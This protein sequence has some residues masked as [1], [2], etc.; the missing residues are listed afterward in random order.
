MCGNIIKT[1]LVKE[2]KKQVDEYYGFP[3]NTEGG[4]GRG[5]P[6]SGCNVKFKNKIVE[7]PWEDFNFDESFSFDIKDFKSGIYL[8]DKK[9]KFIVKGDTE[10]PITYLYSSN[11]EAAYNG[12]G[13]KSLY[14][15]WQL[16]CVD[17]SDHAVIVGFKRPVFFTPQNGQSLECENIDVCERSFLDWLAKQEYNVNYICDLDMDEINNIDKTKLLIIG[18]H[19]EYWTKKAYKNLETIINNGTNILCLS[20]NS[21]TWRVDYAD[22]NTKLVCIKE[23]SKLNLLN[24]N[25]REQKDFSNTILYTNEEF[26]L[27]SS[28]NSPEMI[29][30]NCLGVDYMVGGYGKLKPNELLPYYNIVMDENNPILKNIK[31][32]RIFLDYNEYDGIY[33]NF[34]HSDDSSVIATYDILGDYID[35][36]H[37]NEYYQNTDMSSNIINYSELK[38]I[39]DYKEYKEYINNYI[40]TFTNLYTKDDGKNLH[41]LLNTIKDS[42]IKSIDKIISDLIQYLQTVTKFPIKPAFNLWKI[43]EVDGMKDELKLNEKIYSIFKYKKLI[44]AGLVEYPSN[45]DS[46]IKRFSGIIAVKKNDKSG[47]V[48][49]TCCMD[50]CARI[51]FDSVESG[52]DIKTITKNS[53]DILL[54]DSNVIFN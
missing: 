31:N 49:N 10:S 32:D 15:D 28:T 20:G 53:I 18:G 24:T 4:E 23:R 26:A 51:C 42:D 48:L 1:I 21:I 41:S 12:M 36:M 17:K 2:L 35:I 14:Y 27:W 19:S 40:D 3:C 22:N 39:Q 5:G 37:I 6:W 52:D 16:D 25:I 34:I 43:T 47:T 44:M 13:G 7:N 9:I 11:T 50:W 30:F 54:N 38:K 29:P 45:N 8:I 46:I 33:T